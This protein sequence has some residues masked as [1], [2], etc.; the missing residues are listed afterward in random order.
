[1]MTK[2]ELVMKTYKITKN[3]Y[4]GHFLYHGT[5]VTIEPKE[6]YPDYTGPFIKVRSTYG[7]KQMTALVDHREIERA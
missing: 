3:V 5:K 1:M 7:N 2:E 6:N 4:S